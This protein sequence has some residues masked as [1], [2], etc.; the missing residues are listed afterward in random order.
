[1]TPA[2]VPATP[3]PAATTPGFAG[4]S[5]GPVPIPVTQAPATLQVLQGLAG[6]VPV[7]VSPLDQAESRLVPAEPPRDDGQAESCR[8]ISLCGGSAPLWQ[9]D[10][11]E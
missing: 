9:L 3:G 5:I 8:Y 1:A 4:A 2:P 10:P 11:A 6:T 7:A